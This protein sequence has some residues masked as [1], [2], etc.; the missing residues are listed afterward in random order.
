VRNALALLRRIELY[1]AMMLLAV[2]VAVVLAGTIGR[3]G[4]HPVIWSD[5]V[6]QALFVWLAMLS[7]D[8]TLQ[9]SGHFR[10]NAL[11]D[12]LPETPRFLLNLAIK[13]VIAALLVMLVYYGAILAKVFHPR[14]LPMTGVPSSYAGAALPVAY[15][16]ML[17]TA[18]E[19][20]ID[21]IH[22]KGTVEPD[23]LDVM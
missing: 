7:A 11:I 5:E 10:I 17:I 4:G 9:R 20:I 18:V 8:L 3:Y 21:H 15:G 23:V 1:T 6:A 14:P 12:L 22:H 13:I 16:L 2:I 19:Q